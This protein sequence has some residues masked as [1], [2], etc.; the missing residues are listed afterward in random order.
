[1]FVQLGSSAGGIVASI[2][3]V[4]LGGDVIGGPSYKL[5]DFDNSVD[6]IDLVGVL[7]SEF[8]DVQLA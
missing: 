4:S 3:I 5:G 6:A 1:M 7:L 2:A 8:V